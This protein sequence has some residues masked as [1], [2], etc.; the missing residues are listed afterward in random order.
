MDIYQYDLKNDS[1]ITFEKVS[2]KLKKLKN[3]KQKERSVLINDL[4]L[5]YY[6]FCQ[7]N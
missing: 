7:H 4:I 2:N 1:R 5:L 3:I 6:I